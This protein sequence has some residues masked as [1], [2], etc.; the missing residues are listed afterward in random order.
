MR[1]AAE[2]RLRWFPGDARR[3]RSLVH[4]DECRSPPAPHLW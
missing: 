3:W 2:C 1:P 4:D